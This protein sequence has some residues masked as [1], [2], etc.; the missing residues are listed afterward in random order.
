[1]G[2]TDAFTA[3]SDHPT[4]FMG[5]NIS[6]PI[7]NRAAA[8]ADQ[9]RSELEYR[10]AGSMCRNVPGVQPAPPTPPP[11]QPATPQSAPQPQQSPPS[12]R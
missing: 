5:F 11:G 7:K 10:Q 4:Y 1:M 9:I 3:M 2:F 6:I 8:Q 12:Q